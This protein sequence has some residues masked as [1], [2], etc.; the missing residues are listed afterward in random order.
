MN[1]EVKYRDLQKKDTS[2]LIS[3]HVHEIKTLIAEIDKLNWL[4]REKNQEIQN[5]IRDKKEQ[6]A[7]EEERELAFRAEID[8]LKNKLDL[9]EERSNADTQEANRRINSLAEKLLRD[10]DAYSHR[11]TQLNATINGLEAELR[12]QHN[13]LERTRNEHSI[14]AREAQRALEE[15]NDKLARTQRTLADTQ[16][17]LSSLQR[18][19]EQQRAEDNARIAALSKQNKQLETSLQEANDKLERQADHSGDQERILRLEIEALR[20]NVAVLEGRLSEEQQRHA[21]EMEELSSNLRSRVE[22]LQ[23]QQKRS[24]GEVEESRANQLAVLNSRLEKANRDREEANRK[25]AEYTGM[26]S[27]LEKH[28]K[29]PAEGSI[30]RERGEGSI[31][32]ALGRTQ[33]STINIF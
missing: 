28:F 19:S 22:K 10:S 5:L 16:L 7:Q 11:V 14:K 18:A 32:E 27:H 23:A 25:L 29:N 30:C 9:Q 3:G 6:K 26:Y 17:D 15:A 31:L 1:I 20:K 13:E 24:L 12:S 4:L 8:T 21:K 33:E 2:D